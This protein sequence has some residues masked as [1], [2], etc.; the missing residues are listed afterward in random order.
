MDGGVSGILFVFRVGASL[1]AGAGILCRR[2]FVRRQVD[3]KLN[4]FWVPDGGRIDSA[5]PRLTS[6]RDTCL[7][8]SIRTGTS[9]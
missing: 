9:D 6:F 7:R 2:Q 1:V 3:F 4:R 5:A 8:L